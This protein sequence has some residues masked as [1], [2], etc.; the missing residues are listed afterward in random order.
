MLTILEKGINW[1]QKKW[2]NEKKA[3]TVTPGNESAQPDQ[4]QSLPQQDAPVDQENNIT[5]EEFIQEL[6]GDNHS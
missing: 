2:K 6:Y 4:H 1:Y 3:E 5:P